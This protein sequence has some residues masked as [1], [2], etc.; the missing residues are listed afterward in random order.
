M[1]KSLNKELKR[2]YHE[3]GKALTCHN[4]K[5][6]N[7]VTSIKNSVEYYISDN[8]NSSFEDIVKKF[9]SPKDISDEYYN[10]ETGDEISKKLKQ[11]RRFYYV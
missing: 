6:K 5:K 3:I 11:A 7:I 10:N 8:P 9:G 1:T 2:Y 4:R